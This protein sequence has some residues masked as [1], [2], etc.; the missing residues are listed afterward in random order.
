MLFFAQ[1]EEK[2]LE[3]VSNDFLYCELCK[4]VSDPNDQGMNREDPS[5]MIESRILKDLTENH[6]IIQ[7]EVIIIFSELEYQVS[8]FTI[9]EKP[10]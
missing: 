3:Q 10:I 9:E 4:E 7:N 6:E 1:V 8:K 5:G 2:T